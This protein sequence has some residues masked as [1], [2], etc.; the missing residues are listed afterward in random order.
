[1]TDIK[2]SID[3]IMKRKISGQSPE[4]IVW[5]NAK[6]AAAQKGADLSKLPKE[7]LGP[8]F[9]AFRSYLKGAGEVM[10]FYSKLDDRT[11]KPLRE[12]KSKIESA[13][14][15]Y[16]L[17]CKKQAQNAQSPTVKSAWQDLAIAAQNAHDN[18]HNM[19]TH[20]NVQQRK[21][22]KPELKLQ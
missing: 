12:T 4:R 17:E 21:E 3:M 2:P 19:V 6:K 20:F 18:P 15:T 22:K 1:M 13:A 11:L 9:D 14:K 8:L 16:E 10:Q 5:A 7:D